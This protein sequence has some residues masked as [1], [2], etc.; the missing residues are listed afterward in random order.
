MRRSCSTGPSPS[1]SSSRHPPGRPPRSVQVITNTRTPGLAGARNSGI[2]APSGELVAFCDDDDEWLQGK[3]RRPGREPRGARRPDIGHGHPRALR[4]S[5]DGPHPDPRI[6]DARRARPRPRRWRP[7]RRASW[8]GARRCSA[9][10]AS[11]T[12]RSRAAT[13][14]TST[15][16]CAPPRRAGSPSSSAIS[17]TCGGASRCSHG[18]WQMIIDAI[19]YVLAKHAVLRDEP[20]RARPACWAGERS[21]SA[22]LTRRRQAL[23]Q[24]WADDQVVMARATRVPGD[25]RRPAPRQRRA[26]RWPSPTSA[27]AAS[28]HPPVERHASWARA[29]PGPARR[30]LTNRSSST[31]RR[32]QYSAAAVG[33]Q[34]DRVRDEERGESCAEHHTCEQ[35]RHEDRDRIDRCHRRQGLAAR[36]EPD[37]RRL[38]ER[39]QVGRQDRHDPG[40]RRSDHAERR[41]QA[42]LRTMLRTSATQHVDGRQPRSAEHQQHHVDETARRGDQHRRAQQRQRRS[43]ADVVGTERSHHERSEDDH[44]DVGRP[45]DEHEPRRRSPVHVLHSGAVHRARSTV[46]VEAGS[47][48]GRRSR[49]TRRRSCSATPCRTHRRP[50]A[51][52]PPP[53]SARRVVASA[54][55]RPAP[56]P[57]GVLYRQNTALRDHLV[58]GRRVAETESDEQ[59]RRTRARPPRS[60]ASRRRS[61]RWHLPHA[62]HDQ[63]R[64]HLGDRPQDAVEHGGDEHLVACPQCAGRDLVEA[65]ERQQDGDRP[66]HRGRRVAGRLSLGEHPAQRVG[67]H[68]H[69][70]CRDD[71]RARPNRSSA[72][73]PGGGREAGVDTGMKY[74]SPV[75][76]PSEHR[77]CMIANRRDGD[78]E[79]AG[80]PTD[81]ATGWRSAAWRSC[82]RR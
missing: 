14:R 55:G 32:A 39:Q 64:H 80:A 62:G 48:G 81:R 42:R 6:G 49:R 79:L 72:P 58:A 53:G 75:S 22:A 1:T 36:V 20:R 61:R 11:S 70:R 9:R 56:P 44:G 33:R 5:R 30:S 15:G 68:E 74:C 51:T 13:A 63:H 45:R 35:Q 28:D 71:I 40:D 12:R 24:A 60:G 26:T 18:N 3:V 38:P 46:A 21:R 16:S 23:G 34:R 77:P 10:S 76:T 47:S 29:P 57:S 17:S 37:A 43:A 2:M 27:D 52:R 59:H 82:R 69:D 67:E 54:S 19:D 25:R 41:C 31:L 8:S 73:G 7:T 65:G 66:D 78:E 50:R 4:R